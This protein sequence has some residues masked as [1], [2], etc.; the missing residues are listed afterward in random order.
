MTAKTLTINE[1]PG[2][3][4][5][6]PG[7]TPSLFSVTLLLGNLLTTTLTHSFMTTYL[8]MLHSRRTRLSFCNFRSHSMRRIPVTRKNKSAQSA[9]RSYRTHKLLRF[10]A[11]TII[12]FTLVASSS[13]S[14]RDRLVQTA[15]ATFQIGTGKFLGK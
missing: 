4:C 14:R 6:T 13:G 1:T 7:M 5:V 2:F 9:S 15:D 10:L 8:M 3:F 12:F 11:V